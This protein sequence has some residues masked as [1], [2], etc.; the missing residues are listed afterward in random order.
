MS[1]NGTPMRQYRFEKNRISG[2]YF[3]NIN[4]LIN[5]KRTFFFY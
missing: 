4:D 3:N 1:L 2:G 5:N